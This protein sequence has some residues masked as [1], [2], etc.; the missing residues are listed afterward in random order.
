MV[1]QIEHSNGDIEDNDWFH[2]EK[3]EN[4]PPMAWKFAIQS[5]PFNL[6]IPIPGS[7]ISAVHSKLWN[8]L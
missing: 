5:C 7:L 4:R 2:E 6:K 3:E 1:T 8:G